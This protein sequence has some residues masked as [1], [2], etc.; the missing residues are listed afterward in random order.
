MRA[1]QPPRI[2]AEHETLE[3]TSGGQGQAKRRW[4]SIPEGGINAKY[5]R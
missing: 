5:Y 3:T 1:V 2:A 4:H